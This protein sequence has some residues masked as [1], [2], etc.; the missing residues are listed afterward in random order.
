MNET[1]ENE[2]IETETET[3]A[4]PVRE[5]IEAVR[6][7]EA[8][9]LVTLIGFKRGAKTV[10]EIIWPVPTNEEEAQ[11]RYACSLETLIIS[12]VRALATRPNYQ[13]EGFDAEGNFLEAGIDAEG[14]PTK[15]GQEKMQD[16][17]DSYKTGQRTTSEATKEKK[18]L[19]S[20]LKSKGISLADLIAKAKDL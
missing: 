14:N 3:T 4:K 18:E 11:K 2:A 1:N 13:D 16:L 17:A 10:Y 20:L 5:I 7:V 6:T 19:D 9:D 15:D 12:G 8:N